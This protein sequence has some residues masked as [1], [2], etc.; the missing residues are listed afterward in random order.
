MGVLLV[1]LAL[2]MPEGPDIG[3]LGYMIKPVFDQALAGGSQS[4]RVW[5]AMASF[6]IFNIRAVAS[7]AHDVLLACISQRTA[8]SACLCYPRY[9]PCSAAGSVPP[10]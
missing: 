4:A 8:D 9:A 10:R 6:A 5:V 2:V 1:A 7:M 3:N